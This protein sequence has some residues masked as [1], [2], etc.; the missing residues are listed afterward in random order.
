MVTISRETIAF[1][2]RSHPAISELKRAREEENIGRGLEAIGKTRF[3]TVVRA[4]H[5]L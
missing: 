2:H 5:S 3:G 4:I 1:F